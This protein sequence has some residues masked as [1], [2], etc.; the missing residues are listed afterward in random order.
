MKKQIEFF[1]KP[2]EVEIET[3]ASKFQLELCD[4]QLDPFLR[5]KKNERN[6]AI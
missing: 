4:L 2:M 6:E 3:Q 5:S 1:S